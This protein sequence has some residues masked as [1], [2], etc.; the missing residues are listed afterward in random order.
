MS[1]AADKWAPYAPPVSMGSHGFLALVLLLAGFVF[2]ALY[3]LNPL[4]LGG[5][6]GAKAFFLNEVPMAAVASVLL[7]AGTVFLFL[8]AGIYV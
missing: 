8:W 1:A 3:C 2:T 4:G 5:G 6:K 7:G